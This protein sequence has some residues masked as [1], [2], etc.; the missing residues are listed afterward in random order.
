MEPATIIVASSK[1]KV[2][3]NSC[4]VADIAEVS[5]QNKYETEDKD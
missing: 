3:L 5:F 4:C 2:G 1:L